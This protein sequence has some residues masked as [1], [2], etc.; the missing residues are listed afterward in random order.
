[1]EIVFEPDLF[2]GE[3]AA[4]LIKELALVLQVSGVKILISYISFACYP[5]C[6]LITMFRPSDGV[7]R[8][9]STIFFPTTLY[10]G[11]RIE[12]TPAELHLPKGP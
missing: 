11:S 5:I 4:A 12:L 1:M 9:F 8:N 10:G 3:E 6:A 7:A 2:D